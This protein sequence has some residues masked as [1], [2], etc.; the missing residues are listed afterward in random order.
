MFKPIVNERKPIYLQVL[1]VLRS[2][3]LSG[4]LKPGEKL[5]SERE[6]AKLLN[7]SRTSVREALKLLAAQGLIKIVHGQGAFVSAE[8]PDH[9][10]RKLFEVQK[11]DY[12]T[13]E[14]IMAIRRVLEVKAAEWAAKR[15]SQ[16]QLNQLRELIE[17]TK[18]RIS[19][20][21]EG[22]LLTLIDHDNRFHT[23]IAESTG[24]IVLVN[25]MSNLLDFLAEIRSHTLK[26]EG[27]QIKSLKEHEKIAEAVI[28]RDPEKASKYMEEH[29]RSVEKDVL[30]KVLKNQN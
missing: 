30:N 5:P 16:E 25:L 15:A 10:V 3:I 24:N 20:Q 4:K 8:N 9:L 6:L 14:D 26:I 2:S 7:V 12:K 1:E 29:L 17:T 21:S 23:L 22:T 13:I 19:S 18:N 27:R 28:N 11:T